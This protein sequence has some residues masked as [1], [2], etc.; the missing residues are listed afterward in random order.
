MKRENGKIQFESVDELPA[1]AVSLGRTT[2][3]ATGSW[4]FLEPYYRNLT[5]PCSNQ[6][7]TGLD[8]VSMMEA[9][10]EGRWEDAVRTVLEVNPIPAVTGRVCPHPCQQPCNRKAMGGGVEIRAVECAVGDYKLAHDVK[11]SLPEATRER[12][13]VVGSGPAGLSAAFSLRRL[14]HPVTVHEAADEAGGLLRYGIPAYRLPDDVVRNEIAWL[15][16]LGIRF[17]T[18][19]R[20][21]SADIANLGPTILTVGFGRSR[22]LGIPGEDL[23]GVVDGLC[24]LAQIRHGERP[25]LGSRAAVIGGGNT[26]LDVARS[27]LRLG[28]KPVLVYR[29]S[30][31]EMPAFKDEIEEAKEEGIEFLFLEAPVKVE[32]GAPGV[33]RLTCVQMALGA[34]DASGRARPVAKPGSEHVLEVS[35]VVKALGETLD[36]EV[37]PG[38]VRAEQ[39]KI[40]TDE[41][42]ATPRENVYAAGDAAGRLGYTVSEAIRSGRLA[43]HSMHAHLTGDVVP[44]ASPL[45]DRGSDP[46][47]AKFKALNVAYFRKEAAEPLAIRPAERRVGDFEPVIDGLTAEGARHEATRCFKCGTCTECDNCFHFCPDLAIRRKPGGGYLI[48]LDHCKGCGVCAEECPRAAVHLR[49]SV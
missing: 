22:A 6:C 8:V 32:A 26:A 30:A 13:H 34:P 44:A 39:G 42:Y 29:R 38:G 20:L 12:V 36:E 23:P 5:P 10:E 2:A 7:L 49:K 24:L 14:G 31:R 19:R 15:T 43:A 28:T 1:T 3:N 27:L 33:L 45:A 9:V 4:K 18:G 40:V 37:L 35:A 17:N 16:S 21:K 25:S 48:D 11:P 41:A 46:E 47:V